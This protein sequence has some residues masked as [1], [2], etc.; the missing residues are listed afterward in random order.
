MPLFDWRCGEC[1]HVEI[2]RYQHPHRPAVVDCDQCGASMAR[3]LSVPAPPQIGGSS[4]TPRADPLRDPVDWDRYSP[5][6]MGTATGAE[7]CMYDAART[8]GISADRA[9]SAA[10]VASGQAQ[11]VAATQRKALEAEGG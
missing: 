4:S 7:A 2:D 1:G 11:E 5:E 3:L 10:R 8:A 9:R 6:D